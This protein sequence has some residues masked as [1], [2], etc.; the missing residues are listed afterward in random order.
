MISLELRYLLNHRRNKYN[1]NNSSDSHS[2]RNNRCIKID[3][4]D[5]SSKHKISKLSA[6]STII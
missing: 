4:G 2:E 3:I 6:V 5:K 1:D